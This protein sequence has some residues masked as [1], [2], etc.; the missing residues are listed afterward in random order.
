MLHSTKSTSFSYKY[1]IFIID[2]VA[3]KAG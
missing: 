1:Y 2:N 3:S